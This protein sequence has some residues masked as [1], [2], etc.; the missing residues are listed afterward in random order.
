MDK[1]TA[2][3]AL[4]PGTTQT[5]WCKV[6]FAKRTPVIVAKGISPNGDVLAALRS[7]QLDGDTVACEQIRSYGMAVGK[8]VYDTVEWCG[9]FREAVYENWPEGTPWVY[10]PR[11]SV[12]LKLCGSPRAKDTNV[13]QALLDLYPATGGGKNPAVGTSTNP[14]PLF[15]VKSHMFAALGVAHTAYH[16][17][18]YPKDY[19]HERSD[20]GSAL[21]NYLDLHA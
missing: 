10:I 5:G 18:H 8:E 21:F 14:G 13:R 12:K 11:L 7:G 9:R 15:G 20:V 17:L 3:V 19:T 4:D 1:V 6:D 16:V 2:I